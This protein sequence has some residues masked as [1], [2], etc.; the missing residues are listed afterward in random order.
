MHPT[1]WRWFLFSPW[2]LPRG[3][4]A[5]E[6][7]KQAL[8]P[9]SGDWC[10]QPWEI[11]GWRVAQG[12]P[13]KHWPTSKARGGVEICFGGEVAFLTKQLSCKPGVKW[14]LL[15]RSRNAAPAYRSPWPNWS[16]GLSLSSRPY[17]GLHI[18]S[19][20]EEGKG[21][22]GTI[23]YMPDFSVWFP[24]VF[25]T[26]KVGSNGWALV[27]L[28]PHSWWLDLLW[29]GLDL[30]VIAIVCTHRTCPQLPCC[31]QRPDLLY[32]VLTTPQDLPVRGELAMNWL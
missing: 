8:V 16:G 12:S 3:G 7:W 29:G 5:W 1:V 14:P 17:W 28:G 4:D 21:Q 2:Q 25:R 18:L 10:G 11:L 23:T 32:I 30:E 9:L 13:Q 22:L 19:A 26:D 31:D 6:S 27:T 24:Q 15:A 20:M